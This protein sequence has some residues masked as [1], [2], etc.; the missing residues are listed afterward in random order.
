MLS[1]PNP[2]DPSTL[3]AVPHAV[4]RQPPSPLVDELIGR[5]CHAIVGSR[6]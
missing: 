1:Q 3:F 2:H 5:T 4:T 6:G